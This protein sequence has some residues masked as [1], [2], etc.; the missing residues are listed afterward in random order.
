M[1]GEHGKEYSS[2]KKYIG[3]DADACYSIF[4]SL[5][6]DGQ[7]DRPVRVEHDELEMERLLRQLPRVL[8]CN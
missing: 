8:R 5:R 1:C 3:C 2:V 6:E 7:W 4:V